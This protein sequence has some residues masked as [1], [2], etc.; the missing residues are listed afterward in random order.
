[1]DFDHDTIHL[2]D[3]WQ[4]DGPPHYEGFP[5]GDIKYLRMELGDERAEQD[6]WWYQ[7]E[8]LEAF[9]KLKSVDILVTRELEFYRYF[10]ELDDPFFGTCRKDNVRIVN[11]TTGEWIDKE[12]A[13]PYVD[14]IESWGGEHL[15]CMTRLV[16]WDVDEESRKE[17]LEDIKQL[18]MPRPRINL[19][20][21]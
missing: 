16:V 21:P 15:D 18:Q 11:M 6:F 5:L 8:L 4:L 2:R 12:T 9:P 20:Y 10:I 19:D 1:M 3:S 7:L 14:Y 13:G 17:R